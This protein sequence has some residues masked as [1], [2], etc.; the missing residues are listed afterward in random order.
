GHPLPP[1]GETTLDLEVLDG[2]VPDLDE[3]EVFENK[4]DAV[5]LLRA[6]VAPFVAPNAKPQ[7]I[8]ISLGLCEASSQFADNGASIRA[9]EREFSLMAAAGITVLAAS[10]DSGSAGCIAHTGAPADE[11]AVSYPA[12]SPWVTAVGG[13]NLLLSSANQ[14][15]SQLVWNDT[16][17]FPG[18]AGGGGVSRLFARP[19]Y[20]SGVNATGL[21]STVNRRL[22][23]DVSGLADIA[24]GYATYCT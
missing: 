13:T 8:S 9:A 6:V 21:G 2:V 7:V 15:Q 17:R 1:G 19:G 12:S 5:G 3:L 22:V 20:Q 4:S 24:P 14:I 11:L 18:D 16:S 23:P 10:G